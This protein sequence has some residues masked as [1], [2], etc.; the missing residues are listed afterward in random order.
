[1]KKKLIIFGAA[2]MA[3]LAHFYFT[4]D[5]DYEV[6]GFTV[7]RV[8]APE[9]FLGLP[10]APFEEVES[11]YSPTEYAMFVA[12]GYTRLNSLRAA[13]YEQ[14]K[15]KGYELASYFCTKT[16]HWGDVTHG[17]NCFILEHQVFQP[18]VVIGDDA[19][20]WSGNHF[21]HNVIIGNHCYLASHIV[22]SGGVHIG[23]LTFVGVNA[24]LRDNISIGRECIVGAGALMLRSTGDKEVY[25]A[26]ATEKYP[27]DSERFEKMMEISRS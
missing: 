8:Y 21:G 22:V 16:T 24:T 10:M 19:F 3:E 1:M 9:T 15:A 25:V 17:D 6:I 18:G 2:K 7:D 23:D 27:L 13:K 5:S 11:L 4:H 26:K 12:V 14:A 20:I